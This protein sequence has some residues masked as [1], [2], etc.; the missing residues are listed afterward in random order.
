[1]LL[2]LILTTHIPTLAASQQV[3]P[4]RIEPTSTSSLEMGLAR[5]FTYFFLMLGPI[6]ILIPFVDLT[7]NADNSFRR[8]LAFRA[9]LFSCFTGAAAALVGQLLLNSWRV[10]L[11]ALLIAA[12]IVLFLVA[13]Q[14]ILQQYQPLVKEQNAPLTPSLDAAFTPLTF[15]TIITP[16]GLAV[17]ILFMAAASTSYDFAIFGVFLAM[18]VINL[19]AMLFAHQICQLVQ[20]SSLRIFG[21]LIGI[22][23]VALAIQMLL[24]A[25]RLL[26][27]N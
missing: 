4:E 6:K 9:F 10:S 5:I 27:A 16:F 13:L 1:M 24:T 3:S 17:L 23:Q 11:P 7:Q 8:K 12:G 14:T 25:V 21:T 22:L 19:L 20:L 26:S 18:M 15:P 2:G